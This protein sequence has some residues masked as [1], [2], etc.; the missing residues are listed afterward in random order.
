M[1]IL[2]KITNRKNNK[3]Y[4][5]QAKNFSARMSAHRRN[6]RNPDITGQRIHYAIHKHGA[7]NFDYEIIASSK[8]RPDANE[9]ED[10][11]IAQYK[12]TDP[13]FG[14][15]IKPGGL[16]SGHAEITKQ[17][18]RNATINQIAER[19]HPALGSKRTPEQLARLSAAL[20][21]RD[22]ESIYNE[23]VRRKMSESHKGKPQTKEQIQ[24]RSEAIRSKIGIM[25][26]GA[27]ECGEIE[28]R[29][30]KVID[31]VRYCGMHA[32]RLRRHGSLDE[33]PRI[34]HNKGTSHT[35]EAK[36]KMSAKLKG[37]KA[38]N[39]I[40]F[41]DEQISAILSDPRPSRQIAKDYNVGKRVILRIR[42]E[43]KNTTNTLS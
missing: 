40:Y 39:K 3:V 10:V 29:R 23:E 28:N 12:S 14:Y 9:T 18:I 19:G 2:Y 16:T 32:A 34:A 31:G 38:H 11:L 1:H 20:K 35:P 5:G 6:G 22:H 43:C 8:T 33:R 7:E 36:A 15:N 13:R 41:T 26:C 4:I 21:A 37:R 30:S 24:K 25:I 42:K 27:P 17:K